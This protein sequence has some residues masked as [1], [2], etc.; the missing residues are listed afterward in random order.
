MNFLLKQSAYYYEPNPTLYLT[1]LGFISI[2][3]LLKL[4][5]RNY[6][7]NNNKNL[8]PSPPKLPFI[9]NLHQFGTLPH[10]SFHELSKKHGPLMFL[11]LGQ[12]PA[13]VVSS[14]EVA[15]E[16]IKKH[17]VAFSN[18][19]QTT[20]GKIILYGCSDVVFAPYGEEWRQKRKICVLELLSLKRVKSF[21][22]IREEEVMELVDIIR[23][24]KGF[25][26]NIS[27][28]IIATSNNIVSRCV[29]G[30][31][32]DNPDGNSSFGELGR[33]MMRELAAF[34]VGDFF[35]LLG[36][37]DFLTGQ[38]QEFKA[39]FH[40]LDC[41]YDK[42]LEEHRRM[43]KKGND[44]DK[45][46]FV[47]LLLQVQEDGVHHDFHLSN[48]NLKAILMDVFAGGGD[49]T[50]TLLEWTFAELIKNPK[51]M[52]KVQE[53]VRN[54]VGYKQ[55]I[56]ENDVNKMEYMK[57]VMKEILRLHPPAPLLIP[58]ETLS[59]VKLKGYDIPSKTKVYL[60][61]WTIQRDPEIW[62][63]PEEFIPERFEKSQIDFMGQ[64]LEL[65][66]FGFGRRGCAG[67]SFA[68]A[69]TEHILAN[70]LYWFDWKLPNN[71]DDD[72][73]GVTK[74]QHIDMCE[75]YGLTVCKKVPLHLQPK[76]YN[77]MGK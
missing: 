17:D 21:K 57:C 30:Q 65:I 63:N 72:D 1:I 40:A 62:N 27:E 5:R 16:I 75:I 64:H 39:T 6:K 73:V 28:L 33:K 77:H 37:L 43:I 29:L 71:N 66:P 69:S 10:R 54:V 53:E 38:I 76:L 68:I 34:S 42:V 22:Y 50:S 49:T 47:D 2:F 25:S 7:P 15:E 58:R 48:D 14:V 41:F 24:R 13:I 61:A 32:Y 26:I 11:Q 74:M 56:D 8:P 20:S 55:K 31:K 70:L 19:P 44:D 60:N 52:K 23:A 46:D 45:K 59:D 4:T 35:P 12:T 18:K 36:W 51:I 67:I 9:G 3:L